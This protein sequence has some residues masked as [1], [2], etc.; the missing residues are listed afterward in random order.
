MNLFS[1][2]DEAVNDERTM[3]TCEDCGGWFT[4]LKDFQNKE[5]HSCAAS[6]NDEPDPGSSGP[7]GNNTSSSSSVVWSKPATLLLIAEF[8][9]L[10]ER[11]EAGFMRKKVMWEIINKQLLAQGY[12]F[13][14]DQVSGRWKSL[15]RGYRNVKDHN[16]KSGN[17]QKT[18]EYES[19]LDD[20]FVA[21]PAIQPEATLSL[22]TPK[23]PVSENTSEHDS[24]SSPSPPPVKK[25]ITK[26]SNSK[27]IVETFKS[28]LEEQKQR[29]KD[30]WERREKMH[31]EKINVMQSL[32]AAISGNTGSDRHSNDSQN[33]KHCQQPSLFRL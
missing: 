21:D 17:S 31:Q 16:S 28:Y 32:V 25:K 27:E 8:S 12:R 2:S 33:T 20:L 15:M 30:E 9:K 13:T 6:N 1:L 23:R 7:K 3:F 11:Q 18:F 26:T 22:A 19:A 14:V 5:S 10:K 4:S 29:D 24:T